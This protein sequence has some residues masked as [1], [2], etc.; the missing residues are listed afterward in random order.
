MSTF[1]RCLRHDNYLFVPFSA[2]YYQWVPFVLALQMMICYL[3]RVLWQMF[4]Y[5][6]TGTDLEFLVKTA[7]EASQIPP[8]ER[9][10]KIM[11]IAKIMEE[12]V[13]KHRN[14]HRTSAVRAHVLCF[15]KRLGNML[16]GCYI[17]MK[18]LYIA[19]NVAQV[20]LM[21][22]F[23]G[24]NHTYVSFGSEV[25]Q[26][27]VRGR[28]WQETLIFPRITFCRTNVKHLGTNN[29]LIAQCALPVNMLNEKI[30]IFLWF[31]MVAGALFTSISLVM[32]LF[33]MNVTSGQSKFIR[34]YLRMT[35]D[36]KR[37]QKY[38]VPSFVNGFLRKDGVFLLRVMSINVGDLVMSE[39]IKELWEIYKA[40]YVGRNMGNDTYNESDDDEPFSDTKALDK[41]GGDE[42]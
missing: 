30:Y 4:T 20:I 41:R 33:R 37:S 2:D 25:L 1:L 6:R 17:L 19:N 31:W 16:C 24:F 13:L 18:L 26:D 21:Q 28:D 35:E 15:G 34:Q 39:V 10:E 38:M 3:P 29:K 8:N 9:Q 32:W 7:Q 12:M 27:I 5:N 36:Y 40:K 23:L 42:E 11:H 22:K 14:F